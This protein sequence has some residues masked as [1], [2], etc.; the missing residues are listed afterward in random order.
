MI[1]KFNE[2]KIELE[3]EGKNTIVEIYIIKEKEK[4]IKLVLEQ[5]EKYLQ[6]INASIIEVEYLSKEDDE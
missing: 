1:E 2:R 4:E 5:K 3:T 6:N